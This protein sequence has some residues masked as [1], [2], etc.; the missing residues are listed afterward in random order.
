MKDGWTNTAK[1][2]FIKYEDA[3]CADLAAEKTNYRR[4]FCIIV[5]TTVKGLVKSLCF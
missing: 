2:Y 4:T 3:K 5:C 1:A